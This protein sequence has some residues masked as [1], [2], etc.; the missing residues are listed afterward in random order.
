MG[1]GMRATKQQKLP[2]II[3]I[4]VLLGMTILYLMSAPWAKDA[5]TRRQ[6]GHFLVRYSTERSQRLRVIWD[7]LQNYYYKMHT[8][9]KR[10]EDFATIDVD[11]ALL[12]STPSWSAVQYDINYE[13]LNSK[14]DN[15]SD[16]D[17]IVADPGFVGARSVMPQWV[18]IT[19]SIWRQSGAV[20]LCRDGIIR[21]ESQLSR[22]SNDHTD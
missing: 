1:F 8:F 21:L 20:V 15:Q 19:P 14:S 12:L 13:I 18:N 22:I 3:S 16:M 4:V 5:L 7:A 2:I 6:T 11:V 10:N 17:V 9:P